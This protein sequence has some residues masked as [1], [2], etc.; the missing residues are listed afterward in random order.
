MVCLCNSVLLFD[1]F[2]DLTVKNQVVRAINA[3]FTG[4]LWGFKKY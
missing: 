2:F 3:K 4:C 1:F